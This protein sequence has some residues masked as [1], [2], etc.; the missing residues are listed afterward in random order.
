MRKRRELVEELRGLGVAAGDMLVV[1]ASLRALGPVKG[2]AA[3]VVRAL[4][5]AVGDG[6]TLVAYVDVEWFQDEDS[7][8]ETPVFDK[9]TAT[10]A[11]D[12]GVLHEVMRTWPG[13]LRSDHPDAGVVAIG[14]LSGWITSMHPFQY[15]MDRGRRLR[16]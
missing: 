12:H 14:R 1:H 15:G 5:E 11:R 16:G 10:A 6:G 2:G 7:E 3:E 8:E 13:A 9:A 4:Q